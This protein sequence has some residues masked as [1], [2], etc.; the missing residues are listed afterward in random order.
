MYLCLNCHRHVRESVCPF[1][2]AAQTGAPL[3]APQ[4]FR[5]GMKRSAI[6]ASAVAAAVGTGLVAVG[7][8]SCSSGS[9]H[10]PPVSAA[11]AYGVPFDGHFDV[12]TVGD[13]YGIP[14][15]HPLD[16]VSGGDAYGIAPLDAPLDVV[17]VDAPADVVPTDA[18]D[19]GDSAPDSGGD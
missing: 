6:L 12:L 1:C 19:A 16:V 18:A 3:P 11:D 4:A 8:A 15:G 7:T 17:P 5:V 10:T 2:G 13:A 14:D 9:D